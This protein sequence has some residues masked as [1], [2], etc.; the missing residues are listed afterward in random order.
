MRTTKAKIVKELSKIIGATPITIVANT[1]VRM[2]KKNNPF[3]GTR[4]VAE[5]NGMAGFFY[6]KAVMKR[7]AK[8]GKPLKAWRKGEAWFN[9]LFTKQGK[10]TPLVA[11]KSDPSKKYIR[12]MMQASR[13]IQYFY[14][15][16]EV[17]KDLLVPFLPVERNYENQ[18][19]DDPVSIL[20]FDLDNVR[21][22]TV[23]NKTYDL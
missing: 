17:P 21:K 5:V 6:D 8:E 7:L 19:L 2:P 20:T 3:Y 11:K 4:K 12:I 15:G 16:V 18:G 1:E 9:V 14:Q 22:I 23:N 10:I 13:N